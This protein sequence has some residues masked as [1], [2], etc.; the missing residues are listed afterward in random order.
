MAD[1]VANGGGGK[2]A[3]LTKKYGPLPGYAYVL[4][5]AGGFYLYSRF[6]GGGSSDTSAD[7]SSVPGGSFSDGIPSGSVAAP[8][9]GTAGRTIYGYGKNGGP[10]Y[11]LAAYDAMLAKTAKGARKV[12]GYGKGGKP[13]YSQK[14]W[15]LH[16]APLHATNP[17]RT[18][19]SPAKGGGSGKV[20][21]PTASG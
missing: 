15:N 8:V 1:P 9:A 16:N 6:R 2:L 10:F 12:Y 21:K 7:G 13:F 19:R 20:P 18:K 3:I 17:T 11:S 4:I 5:A 14:Q